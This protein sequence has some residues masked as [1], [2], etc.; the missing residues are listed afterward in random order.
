MDKFRELLLSPN[1]AT[2][3]IIYFE[4]REMP[5]RVV[6]TFAGELEGEGAHTGVKCFP[7]VELRLLLRVEDDHNPLSDIELVPIGG[8]GEYRFRGEVKQVRVLEVLLNYPNAHI[9]TFLSQLV[10]GIA[11][12]YPDTVAGVRRLREEQEKQEERIDE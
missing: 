5:S 12:R 9:H 6:P 11:E 10:G 2:K 3:L 8:G 7:N 1:L 4:V